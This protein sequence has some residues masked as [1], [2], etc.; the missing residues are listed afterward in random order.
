[1]K[2]TLRHSKYSIQY[3]NLEPYFCQSLTFIVLVV[4]W[5]PTAFLEE[6]SSKRRNKKLLKIGDQAQK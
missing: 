2:R 4:S 1:M 3:Y 5:I 6:L